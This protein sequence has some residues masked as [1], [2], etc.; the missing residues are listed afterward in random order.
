MSAVLRRLI[1]LVFQLLSAVAPR[2]AGKLA[3]SLFCRPIK[4]SKVTPVQR[5]MT[6]TAEGLLSKA[7]LQTVEFSGTANFAAG[8]VQT[9]TFEPAGEIV[10]TTLLV[11]GWSSR[12]THMLAFVEPLL[13]QGQRVI[14]IDLPGHGQSSERSFHLPMGVHALHAVRDQ[15]T[16][17]DCIIAHS[18]GGAVSTALIAGSVTPYQPILVKRLVLLS[19]PSSMPDIF[20]GFADM[21]GLNAAA[22]SI[23]DDNVLRLAGNPL[24]DFVGSRQLSQYSLPT[25]VLHDPEDAELPI[26]EAYALAQ[27]GTMVTVKEIEDVGHRRILYSPEATKLA[28]E[29]V[30]PGTWE[31]CSPENNPDPITI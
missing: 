2:T 23:L 15:L 28:T 31:N 22:R 27:A 10:G 25:L 18:L 7:K 3:F 29:F 30:H 20:K 6:Q 19:A 13:S 9:Y 1:R 4:A 17:F 24:E 26:S 21:I 16:E 5:A 8:R 14:A 12:A 11:H